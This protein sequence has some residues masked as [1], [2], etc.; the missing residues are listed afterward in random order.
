MKYLPIFIR[1]ALLALGAIVRLPQCQWSKPDGYGIISRCITPTKHSKA[2]TV[3]LFLGIYCS[4]LIPFVDPWLAGSATVFGS[5]FSANLLEIITIYWLFKK[6]VHFFKLSSPCN[7]VKSYH[8]MFYFQSEHISSM[9]LTLVP[10]FVDI[11]QKLKFD[12]PC[13]ICNSKCHTYMYV[14]PFVHATPPTY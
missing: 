13:V 7:R 14:L 5:P 6:Y 4:R 8:K 3:C 9:K 10:S 1:V 11:L 12:M 2:K